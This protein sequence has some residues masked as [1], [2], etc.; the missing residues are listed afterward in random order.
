MHTALKLWPDRPVSPP[1]GPRE[2]ETYLAGLMAKPTDF[3]KLCEVKE[4][5]SKI[6]PR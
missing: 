4:F 5:Y 6:C 2:G 3:A 1:T